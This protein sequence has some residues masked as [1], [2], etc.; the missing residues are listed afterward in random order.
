MK[1][2][3]VRISL[4]LKIVNVSNSI[5]GLNGVKF[6]KLTKTANIKL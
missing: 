1:N 2:E 6:A 4:S 3:L 5:S